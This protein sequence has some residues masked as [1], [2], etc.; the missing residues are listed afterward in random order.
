MPKVITVTLNTAIDNI[1]EIEDFHIGA[2]VKGS[3][4]LVQSGKGIN[5]ARACSSLQIPTIAFG[6]V[7]ENDANFFKELDSDLLSIKLTPT[8]GK[9]RMNISLLDSN[10][11]LIVHTRTNGYHLKSTQ[12]KSMMN[13]VGHL[14][15]KGDV[16]ILSGSIP[17]PEISN[18]YYQ[19]IKSCKKLGGTVILD[20]SG[21]ELKE[22]LKAFP[23]IVKPNVEELEIALSQR[24]SSEQEVAGG[25]KMLNEAGI[26]QV[27]VS[28]GSEG[29]I[30]TKKGNPGYW[31]GYINEKLSGYP[32]MEI[33][34]GDSMVAGIAA[35]MLKNSGAEDLLKF[36][37]GSATANLFAKSPGKLNRSIV[38]KFAKLTQ[39]KYFK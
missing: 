33:G 1:V 24:L 4:Y 13:E 30:F 7:G 23:D 20:A 31:K 9:T 34:C 22:G 5:V 39:V 3:S 35:K 6:F 15:S 10:H 28:M 14:V 8:D 17:N 37:V 18:A 21:K 32:G 2:V 38:N 25:A 26:A 27:F 11:N 36:A 12:I 29:V 19:L 16:V